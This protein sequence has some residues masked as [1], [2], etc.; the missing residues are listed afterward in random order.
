VYNILN[1]DALRMPYFG[2]FHFVLEYGMIFWGNSA[3]VDKVFELQKR[4]VR[5][6]AGVRSRCSCRGLFKRLD[7]S[8]VP[9]QYIFS[10]MT[11]FVDNLEISRLICFYMV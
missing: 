3:N 11:F 6:M 7:I 9:C 8:P 2:C 5:I 1:I 4:I 10:L